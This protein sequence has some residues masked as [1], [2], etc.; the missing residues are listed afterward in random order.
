MAGLYHLI[1]KGQVTPLSL[2]LLLL[3]MKNTK[4]NGQAPGAAAI[5]DVMMEATVNLTPAEFFNT[6][7]RLEAEYAQL[8]QIGIWQEISEAEISR[9]A[10]LRVLILRMRS[11]FRQ[12]V[13]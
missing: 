8:S 11:E 6:L 4:S 5:D 2:I 10:E 13:S 12:R 9:L 1:I 3:S 7:S